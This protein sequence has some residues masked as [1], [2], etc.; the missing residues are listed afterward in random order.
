MQENFYYHN[1]IIFVYEQG[2]QFVSTCHDMS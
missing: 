1:L 2:V